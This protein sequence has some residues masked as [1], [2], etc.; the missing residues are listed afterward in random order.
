MY[1]QPSRINCSLWLDEK[2][3]LLRP[4]KVLFFIKTITDIYFTVCERQH[5][6][7]HFE[8]LCIA[9][10]ILCVVLETF[11]CEMDMDVSVLRYLHVLKVCV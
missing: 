11:S 9:T 2:L 6:R 4:L 7:Y 10:N 8:S 1:E 5:L 3:F